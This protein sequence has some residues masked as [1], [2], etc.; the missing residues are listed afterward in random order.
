MLSM[1]QYMRDK[2]FSAKEADTDMKKYISFFISLMIPLVLLS[3]SFTASAAETTTRSAADTVQGILNDSGISD[4]V[5]NVLGGLEGSGGLSDVVGGLSDKISDRLNDYSSII[6]GLLNGGTGTAGTTAPSPAT[7][8]PNNATIPNRGTV[9]TT[10]P[11]TTPTTQP[12]STT[13]APTSAPTSVAPAT[14]PVTAALTQQKPDDNRGAGIWIFIA[15][16]AAIM[17]I[18][19]VTLIA[20]T[21]HTEFNSRVYDR[22]TIKSVKKHSASEVEFD[23]DEDEPMDNIMYTGSPKKGTTDSRG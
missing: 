13:A 3:A 1:G 5:D 14:E 21:G 18:A 8:A 17:M 16:A 19:V 6:D 4:T 9:G 23:D 2:S 15:I 11:A 20:V 7:A 10:A 12:E 22:S